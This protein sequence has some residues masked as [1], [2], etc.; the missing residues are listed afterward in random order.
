MMRRVM[1]RCFVMRCF[2][3][4]CVVVLT[5]APFM[6]F[7]RVWSAVAIVVTVEIMSML[8]LIAGPS[9][10]A[11]T[12]LTMEAILAPAVGITPAGPWAYAQKDAIVEVPRPVK[13]PLGAGIGWSFDIAERANGWFA[14][15]NDNLRANLWRQGQARKQCCRAE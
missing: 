6:V 15:F 13:A 5:G 9:V 12:S 10:V 11:A 2:V 14:D 4:R 8:G 7:P 1:M 3:M